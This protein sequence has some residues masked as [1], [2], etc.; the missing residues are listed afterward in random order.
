MTLTAW[1]LS[2]AMFELHHPCTLFSANPLLQFLSSFSSS[3]S[4]LSPFSFCFNFNTPTPSWS[5]LYITN[6]KLIH[7]KLC[8][9]KLESHMEIWCNLNLFEP[10]YKVSLFI[11]LFTEITDVVSINSFLKE[12]DI[13]RIRIY[14]Q[15]R[16]LLC[17]FFSWKLI[18]LNTSINQAPLETQD[19]KEPY[20]WKCMEESLVS[21]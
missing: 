15:W 21:F 7:M 13:W 14:Y 20:S 3:L 17:T 8:I 1:H 12:E 5:P 4:S 6:F 19:A 16:I 11:I 2:F 10:I 18:R 9:Y